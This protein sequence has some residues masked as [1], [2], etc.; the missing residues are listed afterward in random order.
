MMGL[1]AYEVKYYEK[2][3]KLIYRCSN[4][5]FELNLEYLIIKPGYKYITGDSLE[6]DQIYQKTK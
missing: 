5:L 1:A 3:K 4:D 2:I 6:I